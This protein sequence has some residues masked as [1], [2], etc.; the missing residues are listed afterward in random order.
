MA[1]VV[2]AEAVVVVEERVAGALVELERGLGAG[3]VELRLERLR[4]LDRDEVV[5]GAEVAEHRLASSFEKSGL[6]CGI[7]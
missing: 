2:G 3:L 4:V 7:T 1:F 6:P 5:A